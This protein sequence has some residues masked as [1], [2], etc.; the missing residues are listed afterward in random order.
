M[1]EVTKILRAAASGEAAENV[2]E[3]LLPLIYDELRRLAAHHMAGQRPGQTLQATA[4]VHN[5]RA[6][7]FRPRP[8]FTK[9]TFGS[10][11]RTNRAASTGMAGAIFS[12][13]PPRRCGG[14]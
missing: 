13:R 9:P 6:K 4:L 12:R 1:N 7:L 3:K 8:W 14:F 11:A 2:T 10:W 5:G